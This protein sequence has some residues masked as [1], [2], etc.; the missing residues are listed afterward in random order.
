[1]PVLDKCE[2]LRDIDR[3]DSSLASVMSCV[4]ECSKRECR[5]FKE[6]RT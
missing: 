1:M 4:E 6:G 3:G 5:K 2:C